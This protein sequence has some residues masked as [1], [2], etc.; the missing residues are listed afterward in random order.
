M[1]CVSIVAQTVDRVLAEME[2][3]SRVADLLEIRLDYVRQPDLPRILAHRSKPVI[4]TI[5]PKHEQGRFEGSEPERLALLRQAIE[6]GADYIDVNCDCPERGA[7]IKGKGA[8]KVIL[9]YHNFKETPADLDRV[10]SSMLTDGADILKIATFANRLSDNLTVLN[11]VKKSPGDLIGICMGERGEI[12]RVLGPLYGS[13]LTFACL[14]P[15][16]ESAPGQIPAA[17]LRNIYAVN[18]LHPGFRLYGIIGN[19]VRASKGYLLHNGL[20]RRHGLNSLYLN[21]LV[22][23][24][25]DFLHHFS[26]ILAGFS[27][28]MPF[29]QEIM[30]GLHSTDALAARIGAVN[31]VV[32]R[33]GQL[34]GYNTDMFGAIRPLRRIIQISEKQ[35]TILGAGGAARAIAVGILEQGGRLTILNR[36]VARAEQLAR[37]LGCRFGALDDFE[38]MATEIL[39]NTTSVGMYP[40]T[41]ASPVNLAAVRN[42]VV[43]DAIYNPRTTALLAAAERNGCPTVSGVEMFLHQAAEQ[44]RLWTGIEPD[45][46]VVRSL[47]YAA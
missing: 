20:F 47:L 44:F 36:T 8:S 35:V 40:D 15:G 38:R 24:L 4:I 31:T 22:D 11:L 29:K 43:F 21:F 12:S 13:Y 6:L 39:I 18:D 28:T 41:G 9:S 10:F 42:M 33:N 25:Q 19:P 37:E 14:E 32:K 5:M 17:A 26:D 34:I 23:D 45:L 27:V 1:I 2:Q 30:A 46:D 3:A 16:K 7:L